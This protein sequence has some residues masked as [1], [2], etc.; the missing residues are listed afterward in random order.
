MSECD[1]RQAER[2]GEFLRI[3]ALDLKGDQQLVF[4]VVDLLIGKTSR[5]KLVQQSFG[6]EAHIGFELSLGF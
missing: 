4:A 3:D 6:F 5:Q 1:L 2:R